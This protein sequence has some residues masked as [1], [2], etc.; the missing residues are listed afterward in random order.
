MSACAELTEVTSWND[1]LLAVNNSKCPWECV[2]E[3]LAQYQVTKANRD[4][5]FTVFLL[6]SS[7]CKENS[8]V[9]R[10]RTFAT[11]VAKQ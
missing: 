3:M 4:W 11:M 6:T 5:A 9:A 8:P 7:N 1:L 2:E 10:T